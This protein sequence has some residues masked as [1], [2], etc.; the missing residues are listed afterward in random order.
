MEIGFC[1]FALMAMGTAM[2]GLAGAFWKVLGWWRE[3]AKGRLEDNKAMTL[4]LEEHSD[5][6]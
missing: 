1:E 6:A 3:E 5:A 4:N 2:V